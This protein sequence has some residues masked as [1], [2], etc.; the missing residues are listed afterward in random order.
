MIPDA[1]NPV[2]EPI[3][4]AFPRLLRAPRRAQ[5]GSLHRPLD[6]ARGPELVEGRGCEL[7]PVALQE[8]RVPGCSATGPA[9]LPLSTFGPQLHVQQLDLPMQVTAFDLQIVGRLGD[10]PVVLAQL[11]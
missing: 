6:L 4:R 1:G 10:V 9:N 3:R 7:S 11:S 8:Q 5:R 2:N